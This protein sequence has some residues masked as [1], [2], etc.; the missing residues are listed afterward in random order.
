MCRSPACLNLL[1]QFLAGCR[2]VL[3]HHRRIY[4]QTELSPSPVCA[5]VL[6]DALAFAIA[7]SGGGPNQESSGKTLSPATLHFLR[8]G[9]IRR[10]VLSAESIRS[11]MSLPSLNRTA[12]PEVSH[13]VRRVKF[14][15]KG[16]GVQISLYFPQ[17]KN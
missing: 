12:L 8:G 16:W 11:K 5:R 9:S 6:R 14:R 15:G 1:Q 2:D 10:G 17:E 13:N 7:T 3:Q 4:H